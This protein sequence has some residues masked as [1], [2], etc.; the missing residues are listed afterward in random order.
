M[1]RVYH[2]TIVSKNVLTAHEPP[3]GEA[4]IKRALYPDQEPFQ[5]EE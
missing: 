3:E 2:K 4:A 1:P 5:R